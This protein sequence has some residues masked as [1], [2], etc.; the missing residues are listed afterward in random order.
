V[1]GLHVPQ[2]EPLVAIAGLPV[3]GFVEKMAESILKMSI[4]NACITEEIL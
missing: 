3:S 2:V 1:S 4:V